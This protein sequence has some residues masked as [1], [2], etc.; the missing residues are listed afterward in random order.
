MTSY[1]VRNLGVAAGLAL[2]AV[3]LVVAYLSNYKHHV[4]SGEAHITVYVASK[5]IPAGTPAAD[6]LNSH[7]IHKTTVLQRNLVPGF[8][9]DPA[10]LSNL[11]VTRPLFTNE[12]VT[13]DSFGRAN[14]RGLQGQLAGTDR[15]IQVSGSAEQLLAG[16][17]RTGD[18]VDVTAT[19]G[20]GPNSDIKVS[21]TILRDIL[22]VKAP[23]AGTKAAITS[24]SSGSNG[25]ETAQL[26]LS[27][28]AARELFWMMQNG[29]WTLTLRSPVQASN[30]KDDY[31][32]SGKLLLP[33]LPAALRAAVQRAQTEYIKALGKQG[34]SQ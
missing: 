6:L 9:D 23:E 22:V 26:K 14:A 13:L 21:R 11:F 32:D 2:A 24:S 33:A 27:D 8:I 17:L 18:H 25:P 15:A 5:P 19:W 28:T 4:Q 3:I 29:E 12:Q 34:G 1:R 7:L 30:G 16:T 20:I 31:D 10:K